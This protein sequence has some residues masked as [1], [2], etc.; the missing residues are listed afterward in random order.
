MPK[1]E[2]PDESKPNKK[3]PA[4]RPASP[5]ETREMLKAFV[6][7]PDKE[8]D[9]DSEYDQAEVNKSDD[10]DGDFDEQEEK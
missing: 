9:K 8:L 2:L 4:A 7:S 10:K 3:S 1:F 5:E 6:L